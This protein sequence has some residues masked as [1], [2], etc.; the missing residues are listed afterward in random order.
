MFKVVEYICYNEICSVRG[1]TVERFLDTNKDDETY[2]YCLYCGKQAQ[3][4]LSSIKGYVRG[5]SNPVKC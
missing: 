5:T 3:K 2:Q 4:V 1:N